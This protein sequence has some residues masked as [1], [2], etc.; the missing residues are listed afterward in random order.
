[1]GSETHVDQIPDKTQHRSIVSDRSKH[2][3]N[4]C[5]EEQ[6][7]SNHSGHIPAGRSMLAYFSHELADRQR[8]GSLPEENRKDPGSDKSSQAKD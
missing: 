6:G 4:C 5:Y 3:H 7:T 2:L 1:M 8:K